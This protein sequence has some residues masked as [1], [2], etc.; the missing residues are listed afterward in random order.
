[1][2]QVRQK[3]NTLPFVLSFE[4]QK[5][6]D[7]PHVNPMK[8]VLSLHWKCEGLINEFNLRGTKEQV[9]TKLCCFCGFAFISF[10]QELRFCQWAEYIYIFGVFAL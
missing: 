2:R 7:G 1:M 4:S 6:A 5:N 3:S 10:I 8:L 9:S